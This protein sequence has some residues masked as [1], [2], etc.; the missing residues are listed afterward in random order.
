MRSLSLGSFILLFLLVPAMDAVG[1]E[2]RSIEVTAS[3]YTAYTVTIG[4]TSGV[5][6]QKIGATLTPWVQISENNG[7][8]VTWAP[9]AGAG[10]TS[11]TVAFPVGTAVFPGTPF[12]DD[13]SG[14]WVR[15]YTNGTSPAST[16]TPQEQIGK[17]SHR[18]PY[19]TVTF[20]SGAT[21]ST[22]TL[23]VQGM[24]VQVTK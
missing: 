11:V 20:M 7:D 19:A 12:W 2:T 16:L 3:A 13:P 4:Q 17:F 9:D 6:W 10:Y 8:T 14:N 1:Q 5:C 21:P 23:P 22:C 24:G 18:F 15:S